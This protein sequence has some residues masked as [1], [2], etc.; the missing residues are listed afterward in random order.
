MAG[1]RPPRRPAFSRAEILATRC[2]DTKEELARRLFHLK[3]LFDVSQEIAYLKTIPEISK[4]LL[5]MVMGTFGSPQGTM[6][7]ADIEAGRANHILLRGL[8]PTWRESMSRVVEEG[9]CRELTSSGQVELLDTP[10]TRRRGHRPRLRELFHSLGL[11]IW[12]PLEVDRRFKGL[13]GLGERMSGEPYSSD[14]RELLCTLASQGAAALRN[15]ILLEQMK[16]EEVIRAN[17][18]RYLSPQVVEK[19]IA[20]DLQ[21]D[22]G[23]DRKEVTILFSDIRGFTSLSES[24]SPDEL[25]EILNE[26]FTAMAASVF[27]HQ[28]MV[29]K[30]IG[31]AVMA[32]FGSL[33]HSEN[34]ARNAAASA[35]QMMEILH[36]LN[37]GWRTRYRDFRVRIGIGIATG[38]VFLGNVG[39]PERMEF[40][41][42][43][44]AVNVASRIS[45]VARPDQ[46]LV[47]RETLQRIGGGF[48]HIS[49]PPVHVKGKAEK[50]EVFG[51]LP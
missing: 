13:I 20:N 50:L 48:R 24:R 18:S 29:D 23:G 8:D 17:L 42:I 25:V 37:E 27:E 2:E 39:S 38:E 46:I 45:G 33:I 34:P 31:D 22:L 3:T 4:T 36:L 6:I 41:V 9:G 16:R 47:D 51:I 7:L 44:D 35:I 14:D 26:Y 30:Y 40:T 32:V 1:R 43:G 49:Y 28:G 19:V 12:I 15:A 11:K 10:P 21:V 5:M